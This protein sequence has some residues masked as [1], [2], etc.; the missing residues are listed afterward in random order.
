MAYGVPMTTI[1]ED[2][3]IVFSNCDD[4]DFVNH[5]SS[6][7]ASKGY[8]AVKWTLPDRLLLVDGMLEIVTRE[9]TAELEEKLNVRA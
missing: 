8:K 2:T 5:R 9:I 6:I 1:P 3:S 7:T 4:D